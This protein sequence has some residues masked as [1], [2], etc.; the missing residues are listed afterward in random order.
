MACIIVSY[1]KFNWQLQVSNS[2]LLTLDIY[3]W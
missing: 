3:R 1:K 2:I